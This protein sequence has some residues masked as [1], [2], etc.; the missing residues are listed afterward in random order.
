M[1]VTLRDSE[2]APPISQ[3]AADAIRQRSLQAQLEELTYRHAAKRIGRAVRDIP[4]NVR[5]RRLLTQ[6]DAEAAADQA[7]IVE[8]FHDAARHRRDERSRGNTPGDAG[9]RGSGMERTPS[10]LGAVG[11]FA[12]L[13]TPPKTADPEAASAG[14]GSGALPSVAEA[15]PEAAEAEPPAPAAAPSGEEGGEGEGG[16]EGGGLFLTAL[17]GATDEQLEEASHA[18][19]E[20]AA[21]VLQAYARGRR[22]RHDAQAGAKSSAAAAELAAAEAEAAAAEAEAEAA[23]AAASTAAEAATAEAAAAAEKA[24]AAVTVRETPLPDVPETEDVAEEVAEVAEEVEEEV[25]EGV[26]EAAEPTSY[27]VNLTITELPGGGAACVAGI[28]PDDDATR[29]DAA[30]VAAKAAAKAAKAEAAAAK[31]AA[32][33]AAGATEAEATAKAKADALAEAE[34]AEAEAAAASATAAAASKEATATAVA[35]RE[36]ATQLRAIVNAL[37]RKGAEGAEEPM[38]A[39]DYAQKLEAMGYG[40]DRLAAMEK[41]ELMALAGRIGMP[42]ELAELFM[43]RFAG[44]GAAA[45]ASAA[46]APAGAPKEKRMT[47]A[48][49]KK[50]AAAA[51]AERQRQAEEEAAASGADVLAR[52]DAE[53]EAR[54]QEEAEEAAA[55][56]AAAEAEARAAAMAAELAATEY[57][58]RVKAEADERRK[59]LLRGAGYMGSVKLGG[60]ALAAAEKLEE[61]RAAAR[62]RGEYATH[63]RRVAQ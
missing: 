2:A 41:E 59:K 52:A 33:K 32:A 19:E 47:V 58:A 4:P 49:R 20:E 15:A 24:A 38:T 51:A 21:T 25:A 22:A 39:T 43:S 40:V 35:A 44:M 18:A 56:A 16:E 54:E 57:A 7:R 17:L 55:L 36:K 9:G 50:Q 29:E 3:K 48:E 42:I 60:G 45:S 13:A 63:V 6:Q 61:E 26:A 12:G 10:G 8:E 11:L 27:R 1:Q 37:K 31:A 14:V 5:L 53:R 34:F 23:E 62:A 28:V 46:A 30:A